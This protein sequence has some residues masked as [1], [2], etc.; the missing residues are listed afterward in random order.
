MSSSEAL[1]LAEK[2]GVS[3]AARE[4]GLHNSQLYGWRSKVERVKTRGDDARRAPW[5]GARP[6]QRLTALDKARVTTPRTRAGHWG[7][8]ANTR[9]SGQGNDTTHWRMA[10][11]IPLVNSKRPSTRNN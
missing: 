9:R 2:I 5:P 4:L 3:E 10:R 8:A 7:R 6:S 1:G 11:T